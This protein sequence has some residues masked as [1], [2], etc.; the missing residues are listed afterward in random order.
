MSSRS[1]HIITNVICNGV[2]G[3]DSLFH[4]AAFGQNQDMCFV[5][6]IKE[7][8]I[9]MD[10]NGHALLYKLLTEAYLVFK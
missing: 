8:K 3:V 6:C 2:D 5:P 7:I 1:N 10:D 4:Q 9:V